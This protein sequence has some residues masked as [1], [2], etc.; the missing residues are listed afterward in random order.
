MRRILILLRP[1]YV[2]EFFASVCAV[3]ITSPIKGNQYV[4][5]A[6]AHQSITNFPVNDWFLS[7]PDSNPIF[8]WITEKLI[9]GSSYAFLDFLNY[10]LIFLGVHYL[11]ETVILLLHI[12]KNSLKHFSV[13]VLSISGFVLIFPDFNN[14]L[15][16]MGF[17]GPELQPSSFDLLLLCSIHWI[18]KKEIQPSIKSTKLFKLKILIPILIADFIHPSISMSSLFIILAFTFAESNILVTFLKRMNFTLIILTLVVLPFIFRYV[19]IEEMIYD[20]VDLRAFTFLSENRIPYHT[21]PSNFMR[22][23]DSLRLLLVLVGFYILNW[24][25]GVSYKTQLF[26]RMLVF[27][28]VYISACV[29]IIDKSVFSLL[30]PWRI[31]GALYPLFA[32]FF[33]A[34]LF[35]QINNQLASNSYKLFLLYFILIASVSITLGM[36]KFLALFLIIISL[37]L[38][39]TYLSEK[40]SMSSKPGLIM[41][42]LLVIIGLVVSFSNEVSTI[43]AWNSR[44]ALFPPDEKLASL[45]SLGPGI[46]PP[47]YMNFRVDYGLSIFVDSQ[48]PPFEPKSLAEWVLRLKLSESTQKNPNLVCTN[49]K[50]GSM[51]WVIFSNEVPIPRCFGKID[52]ISDNWLL[53]T[54]R[55]IK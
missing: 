29:F 7:T 40:K 17:F 34:Y 47:Q 51:K 48:S 44:F 14:G 11:N 5:F 8:T 45:K 53:A 23:E 52:A 55:K 18:I 39:L 36:K 2:F 30:V 38:F 31:T 32:L 41:V 6:R 10:C 1:V 4:Y 42:G 9:F 19:P 46:V 43:K 16:G 28:S 50:L 49:E 20:E 12:K 21:L 33:L 25:I 37:N 22:F 54:D 27:S 15:G 13:I 3:G 24:K 26:F 35:L